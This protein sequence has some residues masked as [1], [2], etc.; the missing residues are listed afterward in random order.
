MTLR[1]HRLSAVIVV[2]LAATVTGAAGAEPVELVL[3]LVQKEK[4][5]VIETLQQLVLIELGS[6]D[7]EGLDKLAMLLRDRLAALDGD[8]ELV[9]PGADRV[10]LHDTPEA[11]GKA[12]VARFS[13]DGTRRILLLAHMDTVYPPGTLAKRPFR[14]EGTRAYGPGIADDKGGVALILHTMAILKALDFRDYKTIT[15]AING[16]EEISTPGARNLITRLGAEHDL[17]FSCEPTPS[18]KD[19]LA[20]ATSGIAAATL[21]V[22]GRSSHAGVNPG[23]GPQCSDR[24]GAP[25]SAD[26]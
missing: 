4:P 24:A 11:I 18:P 23:G 15:V 7:K 10:R 21:T 13:G 20:L 6:R 8:V 25:A 16:D 3:S 1:L 5:A 14:I 26:A 17:V 19:Q 2:A 12:V 9:E 22:R